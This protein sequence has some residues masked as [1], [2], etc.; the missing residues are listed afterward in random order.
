MTRP[1]E[2]SCRILIF[3]YRNLY[4]LFVRLSFLLCLCSL[5]Q[6]FDLENYLL[7]DLLNHIGSL[8]TILKLKETTTG[9]PTN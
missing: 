2:L 5:D 1:K 3:S 9:C 7:I 8:K 6:E 4:C